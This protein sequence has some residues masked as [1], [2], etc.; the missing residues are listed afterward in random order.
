[1]ANLREQVKSLTAARDKLGAE[2][3]ALRNEIEQ[4]H[5]IVAASSDAEAL[6]KNLAIRSTGRFGD[7]SDAE[8]VAPDGIP[9]STTPNTRSAAR[10]LRPGYEKI[11]ELNLTL[12]SLAGQLIWEPARQE[13]ACDLVLVASQI[14]ESSQLLGHNPVT[15]IA[16]NLYPLVHETSLRPGPFDRG[17]LHTLCHAS[18]FLAEVL[19]EETLLKVE[20]LRPPRIVAVD[21][22]ADLLATIVSS[23]EFASLPTIGCP[24]ARD[25]LSTLQETCCDLILLDIGLPDLN[26]IDMCACIRAL[27]KH[28]RTPIVFLTGQNT[29]ENRSRGLLRGACDF[30]GKPFNMVELT[31][32]LHTRAL[33]NQ[34]AAA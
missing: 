34:L 27:P 6:K 31:L 11:A 1:M 12:Q 25:A 21:D 33:K 3:T 17:I 24:S 5:A 20:H 9:E 16:G 10:S 19:K 28:D 26:G 18:E 30:I 29:A 14:A 7:K 13:A 32:R 4:L 15:R 2:N 23:L 8:S 22:D